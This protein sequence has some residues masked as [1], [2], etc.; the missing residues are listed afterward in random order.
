MICSVVLQ[1]KTFTITASMASVSGIKRLKLLVHHRFAIIDR[2][3]MIHFECEWTP[4]ASPKFGVQTVGSQKLVGSAKLL[5]FS[6]KCKLCVVW[7]IRRKCK[8][9]HHRRKVHKRYSSISFGAEHRAAVF[10][11]RFCFSRVTFRF[12]PLRR[13]SPKQQKML[14]P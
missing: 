3:T 6:L 5:P 4:S 10:T 7:G 1:S 9:W 13:T 8:K 11:F 12:E 2:R 14:D